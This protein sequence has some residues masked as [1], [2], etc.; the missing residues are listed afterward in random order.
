MAAHVRRTIREAV[1]QLLRDAGTAAGSR[2]YDHPVDDR[3]EF[4]ALVVEDLGANF[5][6]GNVTEAQSDMD[7]DGAK[8]RAYRFCVIAEVKQVAGSARARDDLIAAVETAIAAAVAAGDITGVKSIEPIA[9]TA[10][11]SNAGDQPI[12]R[13]LQVFEA[14]YITPAGDPTTTI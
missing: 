9:Y 4:P 13:G 5:S 14:H 3:K 7:I 10:A 1:V 8:N 2:V 12:R 11:D 6:D